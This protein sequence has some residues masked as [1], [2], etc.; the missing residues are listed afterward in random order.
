MYPIAYPPPELRTD[1]FRPAALGK[2]AQA[3]ED[4]ARCTEV[5]EE[6]A[7]PGRAVKQ[8]VAMTATT[9][10]NSRGARADVL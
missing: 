9:D 6:W 10:R 4:L 5:L 7:P 3:F 2:A 8:G 1:R